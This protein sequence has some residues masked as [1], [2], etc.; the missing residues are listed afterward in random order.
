MLY[1]LNNAAHNELI[2][3]IKEKNT[4]NIF[5]NVIIKSII[6]NYLEY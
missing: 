6:I 2:K 5:R 3:W 4:V 1:V